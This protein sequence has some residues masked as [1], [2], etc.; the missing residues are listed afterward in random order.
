MYVGWREMKWAKG[1]FALIGTV[2]V[3]IT[4]LVGLLSGL[5]KG[6]G[7]QSTSAVTGL[8]TKTLV[9]GG[10]D[11]DTSSVPVDLVDGATPLGFS[12]T[13]AKSSSDSGTVEMIG[14]PPG[15]D[16]AP[17]ADGVGKGQVVLSDAAQEMLGS[18]DVTLA[19]HTFTV[20]ASRGDASYSHMP[21]VWVSLHDWQQMT[22]NHDKATVLAASGSVGDLPSGYHAS[23]VKDSLSAIGSYTSENGSLLMIRGFLLVISAL[24]VGAFFTVWTYQRS[25]EIAILKALGASTRSLLGDALGQAAVV[26]GVAALAGTGIT[27][28]VGMV[29]GS[30]VPFGLGVGTLLG[31]IA[32]LAG[33]GLVGAA[34]AVR[35]VTSIDPLTA[36]SG[37]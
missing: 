29:A 21:V 20:A 10:D 11:F 36:L 31:P 5:T 27:V 34:L 14:V 18:G 37:K 26:L 8:Q 9:F 15:S 17:D 7:D 4:V 30:A 2:I 13:P 12:T 1:R 33:L 16:V 6:L 24:V 28:L 32:L 23:S 25:G 3:L 22:D 19:G 35:K